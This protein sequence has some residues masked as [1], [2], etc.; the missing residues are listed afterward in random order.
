MAED[1]EGAMNRTV[2][3]SLDEVLRVFHTLENLQQFFHQPLH[4]PDIREVR[5]FLG[6][7]NGGANKDIHDLYYGVVWNWLPADVQQ[8]IES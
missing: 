1:A 3:V 8:E 6:N 5:E 2:E 4:Y 7:A